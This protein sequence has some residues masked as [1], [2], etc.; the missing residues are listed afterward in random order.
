MAWSPTP[1]RHIYSYHHYPHLTTFT[2]PAAPAT[3]A[4]IISSH[5]SNYY[6]RCCC[7]YCLLASNLPSVSY[8]CRGGRRNPRS[9]TGWQRR[10]WLAA[11]QARTRLSYMNKGVG[12]TGQIGHLNLL[13]ST[14]GS[15]GTLDWNPWFLMWCRAEETDNW[16][17]G[18]I[19]VRAKDEERGC[20][21]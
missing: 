7:Y 3:T 11:G 12:G 10:S 9:G 4:I 20:W 6:Y 15:G 13:P 18:G 14:N 21:W 16:P 5:S 17:R 19:T 8:L 2:T 1:H